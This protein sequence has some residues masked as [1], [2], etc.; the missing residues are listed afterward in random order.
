MYEV[1]NRSPQAAHYSCI[2]E[3]WPSTWQS[4]MISLRKNPRKIPEVVG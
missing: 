1:E 3:P 4:S 2:T